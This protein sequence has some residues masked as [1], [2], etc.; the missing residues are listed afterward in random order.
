MNALLPLLGLI[1]FALA[2]NVPLGYLRRIKMGFSWMFIPLTLGG[3]V[4][5]QL[6]GGRINRQRRKGD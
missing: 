4:A 6:I 3:A 2:I 5:G 1:L